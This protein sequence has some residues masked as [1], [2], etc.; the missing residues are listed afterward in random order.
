VIVIW[1]FANELGLVG[2]AVAAIRRSPETCWFVGE[3]SD[4]LISE[5]EGALGHR[6]PPSYR[7]F[8]KEL[9][10]GSVRSEEIFGLTTANFTDS[11]VP[12]GVWLTLVARREWGLP[13]GLI[14][15]YFDGGVDYYVLD[16]LKE[17]EPLSIWR[18]GMTSAGDLLREAAESFGAFL[19]GIVE[20]ELSDLHK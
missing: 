19:I 7:L 17:D 1:E 12:N 9:G 8:V 3:R 11:S 4:E 14:V 13:E 20:S 2:R 15:V 5:A 18:P 16:C 6:F 10:A